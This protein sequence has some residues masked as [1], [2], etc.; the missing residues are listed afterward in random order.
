MLRPYLFGAIIL[1]T[2]LSNNALAIDC[3]PGTKLNPSQLSTDLTGNTVCVGLPG[4]W[5][6]QEEHRVSG[7]LWDFHSGPN[8]V[9]APERLT[10]NDPDSWDPTD[11]VGTWSITGD[12]VTYTYD[13]GGSYEYN[14]HRTLSVYTFCTTD[15]GTDTDAVI[16]PGIGGGC[17]L[18]P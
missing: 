9:N 15:G 3:S 12:K 6:A 13:S 14:L 4:A 10:S 2:A 7:E 5:K 16:A 17:P 18:P 1:G 11:K 8:S